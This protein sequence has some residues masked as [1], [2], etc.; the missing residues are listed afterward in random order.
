MSKHHDTECRNDLYQTTGAAQM[1]GLRI[2]QEASAV[3]TAFRWT[4][5]LCLTLCLGLGM[6]QA[7]A[8]QVLDGSFEGQTASVPLAAPWIVGNIFQVAAPDGADD[9]GGMPKQGDQWASLTTMGSTNTTPP[10]NPGGVTTPSA[11]GRG[12]QQN[13]SY[14]TEG[15]GLSFSA[16]FLDG[17]GN[18]IINDWMS[19]DVSDGITTVNLFYMDSFL[20]AELPVA[21]S[22]AYP[23]LPIT[24]RF[25]V[26]ADLLELFPASTGAT[27]FTLSALMGN[28][29]DSGFQSRG[30]VDDFELG[31]AAPT[32][33]LGDRV[34]GMVSEGDGSRFRFEATAGT[35]LSL[36]AVRSGGDLQPGIM[37]TA[38]SGGVLLTPAVSVLSSKAAGTKKF[39]LTETGVYVVDVMSQAGSGPYSLK[40][41]AKAVTKVK[42]ILSIGAVEGTSTV[43]AL[44][45]VA[46][47][48][49]KRLTVASLKPKGDFAMIDG[50]P[51]DLFPVFLPG[52]DPD[53]DPLVF[54]A[55]ANK[56]G[57]KVTVKNLN[58]PLVGTYEFEVGGD[59][60]SIGYAKALAKLS[61]PKGKST[62][63]IP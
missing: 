29:Q 51:A 11:G 44:D 9:D 39:P 43:F 47:T 16:S 26:S 31:L 5:S 49:L 28:D 36:K 48:V 38:P 55:T 1:R 41:K 46:G 19:V 3:T 35:L 17:E 18:D 21:F 59:D 13:F 32:I 2:P 61:V 4:T 50:L 24:Q 30:Y 27:V 62:V 23:E 6:T 37:L 34:K 56:S 14:G 60:G 8:A 52:M 45:A 33:V 63:E 10:D 12:I 7:A 22:S 58:L 57:R 42:E 20:A 40:S 15:T 25:D 53:G 54:E